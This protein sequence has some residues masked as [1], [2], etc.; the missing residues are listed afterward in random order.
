MHILNV[1]VI[2]SAYLT[3][4]VRYINST[5]EIIKKLCEKAG[6]SIRVTSVIDPSKEYVNDHIEEFDKRVNYDKDSDDVDDIFNCAIKNLNAFQ[7]SNTEK[8]RQVLKNIVNTDEFHFVIEDDTVVNTDHMDNIERCFSLVVDKKEEW[9][10][11]FTCLASIDNNQELTMVNSREQYK[12]LLSK[13]SYF[14]KPELASKLCAYLH[15]LKHN[16]KTS[17]SKFIWYSDARSFVL[18]KHIFLEGT[19]IGIFPSSL[20][21]NNFL[22]QNINF[23]KL[24][25]ISN[26]NEITNEMFKEALSIYSSAGMESADFMHSMGIVY[27]KV[28]DYQNSKK[29]LQEACESLVKNNGYVSQAN[30]IINN[31]IN[32]HKYEQDLLEECKKKSSKYSVMKN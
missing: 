16:L 14:I 19:K 22:Y 21:G 29:L 8:H 24:I 17:M 31:A 7:I 26:S 15:T 23:V 27:Y 13:S 18:N 11:V 12:Q 28:K 5:L 30:D 32:M 4:R 1:Y 9:D 6:I 25:N 2:H 3:N 20:S 10:I